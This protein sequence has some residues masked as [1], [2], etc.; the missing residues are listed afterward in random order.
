MNNK[1]QMLLEAYKNY[2]EGDTSH[3]RIANFNDLR[4][5]TGH[6]CVIEIE[7]RLLD[8]LEKTNELQIKFMPQINTRDDIKVSVYRYNQDEDIMENT[9]L[10][11]ELEQCFV[12]ISDIKSLNEGFSVMVGDRRLDIIGIK[13]VLLSYR[14]IDFDGD[15]F[16]VICGYTDEYKY[17]FDFHVKAGSLASKAVE[18]QADMDLRP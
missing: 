2:E 1:V 3:V 14:D 12:D 17:E 15:F 7:K 5:D 9:D 11:Q 8:A 18:L 4:G 13:K 16:E 6:F 10:Y